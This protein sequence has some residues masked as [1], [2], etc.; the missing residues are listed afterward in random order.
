MRKKP[1]ILIAEDEET[2]VRL[3]SIGLLAKGKY[4]IIKA[5]DGEQAVAM[6]TKELPDIILMG[7]VMPKMDGFSACKIIKRNPKTREIPIIFVTGKKRLKTKLMDT[8]LGLS[9]T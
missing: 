8:L 7:G 3:M 2:L 5:L 1:K 9:T 6:A 4:T